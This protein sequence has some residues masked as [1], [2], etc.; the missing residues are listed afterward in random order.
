MCGI[1]ITYFFLAVQ[2]YLVD[3]YTLHAASALAANTVVRCIFGVT[4]LLAGPA[5]YNRLGLGWGNTL[6]GCLALT[7][8]PACLW[9]LKYG[10][11]IRKNPKF[12]PDL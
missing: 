4:I 1:G 2:T 8:A 3:V 9:L 5:L 10:E 7:V 11:R 12:M 6:L